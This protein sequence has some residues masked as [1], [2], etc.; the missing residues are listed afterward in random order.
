MDERLEEIIQQATRDL[1]QREEAR[2]HA[3]RRAR[4]VR[5]LSKQAIQYQHTGTPDKAKANIDEAAGLLKEAT[6]A[7]DPY[8]EIQNSN[9]MES[10]RQEY[11][12]ASILHTLNRDDSYPTPEELG[13]PYTDYLLGLADVPGELRRQTLSHLMNDEL[14][15]ATSKLEAMNTILLQLT[16]MEEGSLL[17]KGMRRKMDIIRAVNEKTQSDVA[18]ELGRQKLSRRLERLTGQ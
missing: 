12:E 1:R 16:A 7:A 18:N 10:A 8:P 5:A 14:D 6:Q 4:R 13:L 17:L 3:L 2:D 11:A 9:D 15:Q